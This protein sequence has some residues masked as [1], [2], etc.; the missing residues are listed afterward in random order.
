MYSVVPSPTGQREKKAMTDL[1]YEVSLEPTKEGPL[2]YVQY[3]LYES[4][5]SSVS[6]VIRGHPSLISLGI[7]LKL[8]GPKVKHY[9]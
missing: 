9:I 6:I 8:I 7:Y 1:E 2:F 4:P 3:V 5:S